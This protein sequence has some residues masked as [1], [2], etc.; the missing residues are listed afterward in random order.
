MQQ[1]A[2]LIMLF[3]ESVNQKWRFCST[4]YCKLTGH[5]DPHRVNPLEVFLKMLIRL[6]FPVGYVSWTVVQSRI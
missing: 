4:R 5:S 6:I 3:L 2:R 1:F